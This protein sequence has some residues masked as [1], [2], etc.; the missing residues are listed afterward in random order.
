M[1]TPTV[2]LRLEKTIANSKELS[3][4][5]L[6]RELKYADHDA[7]SADYSPRVMLCPTYESACV[8]ANEGPWPV[9]TV[10]AEYGDKCVV[11]RG[12]ETLAHHGS[13]SINPAPC[14]FDNISGRAHGTIIVSH[15]DL[16]AVGGILA[17][18]GRKPEDEQFGK[19]RRSLMSTGLTI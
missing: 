3:E 9:S 1:I 19:Q 18:D 5:E 14:L 16:D 2:S 15:L 11:G 10:E 7:L 8:L 12:G 17:L 13:R 6:D 4:E